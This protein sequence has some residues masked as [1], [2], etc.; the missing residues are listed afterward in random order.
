[1]ADDSDAIRKRSVTIAGHRTSLSLEPP[2][3]DALKQLAHERDQSINA[4]IGSIDRQASA[5]GTRDINLSSAVR[6]YLLRV[7]QAAARGGT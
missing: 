4:L 6:V 5:G 2:F 3:W 1:M 7:A